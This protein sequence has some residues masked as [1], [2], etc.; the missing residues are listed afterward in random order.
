MDHRATA[1]PKSGVL[2]SVEEILGLV[3]DG[4]DDDD[5]SNCNDDDDAFTPPRV[6]RRAQTW[7]AMTA[8]SQQNFQ[9]TRAAT[10]VAAKH[11]ERNGDFGTSN[12]ATTS[13]SYQDGSVDIDPDD[14]NDDEVSQDGSMTTNS[15]ESPPNTTRQL[16][17]RGLRPKGQPSR[18]L[19]R[20]A[21]MPRSHRAIVESCITP[22]S[23]RHLQH[24]KEEAAAAVALFVSKQ[25]KNA[26]KKPSSRFEIFEDKLREEE[27]TFGILL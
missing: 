13:T 15:P 23:N 11:H 1:A 10:V 18:G 7:H 16:L 20:A 3:I 27:E 6:Q 25:T 2:L 19:G 12:T 4:D 9:T 8:T 22:F 21:S 26:P 24:K 17:K 14:D 5:R